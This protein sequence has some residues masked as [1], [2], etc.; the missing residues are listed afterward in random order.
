[1]GADFYMVGGPPEDNYYR[2]HLYWWMVELNHF[3]EEKDDDRL[4]F[5]SPENCKLLA[6]SL[7][8]VPLRREDDRKDRYESFIAFLR[9]ASAYGG[10]RASI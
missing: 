1:M 6:A 2:G 4:G 3:I 5:I 8:K 10:V 9:K 7:E